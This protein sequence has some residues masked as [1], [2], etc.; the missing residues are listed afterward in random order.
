MSIKILGGLA[1]G[2]ALLVPKGDLIR[3]TSVMLRR[4]IFDARQ[5]MSGYHFYDLCAGTGAMGLEALSRGAES[6]TLIEPNSKVY[7]LTKKN[8]ESIQKSSREVGDIELVKSNAVKWLESFL[9]R[10]ELM[11]EED[12]QSVVLFLDPPYLLHDVYKSCLDLLSK[13]DFTGELWIESDEQ[14]G[15]KKKTLEQMFPDMKSYSQGTS[16]I[17]IV[18]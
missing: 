12:K 2:Q 1:K 10:Y 3:P 18:R 14:K 13:I 4:K 9:H 16:F 7:S 5:D 8:I 15:I 6:A 17:L 11:S